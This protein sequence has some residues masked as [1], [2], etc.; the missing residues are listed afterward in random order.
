MLQIFGLSLPVLTKVAVDHILPQQLTDAVRLLGIAMLLFI[1][2][3]IAISYLRARLL[4]FLE[5]RLDTRM[6]LGFFQ[7]LLALP[8]GFF[9]RHHRGDLLMRLGNNT[10]IRD[11]M[12]NHT[13]SAVLDGSLI[14][15]YLGVLLV[16]DPM[17]GTI[18]L[19][20]AVAQVAIFLATAGH[21][22]RLTEKEI[23]AHVE[24]QSYA[25]EA[26]SAIAAVKAAGA[27]DQILARWRN[28]FYRYKN[29]ALERSH[30]TSLLDTATAG[31]RLLAPFLLM[32]VGIIRVLDGS[33]SLGSMLAMNMLAAAFL[34]PLSSLIAT[35]QRL[36][37]VKVHLDRI[38]DVVDT[39]TE[40]GEGSRGSKTRLSGHIELRNVSF[41]YGPHSPIVLKDVSLVVKPGEKLALVG[42]T[43]CGKSTLALLMLGLYQPSHGEILC[44]GVPLSKLDYRA[45]RA[46]FGVVMQDA[47]IFSGSIRQNISFQDPSMDLE[48]IVRSAQLARIHEDIMSMPMAYE[49]RLAEGGTG[50]SGGQKQRLSLARALARDPAVL[51]LDEATSHLDTATEAEVQRNL[52]VLSCT[53]ILIAH[54]ISTIRNAEKIVLLDQG[55][56]LDSGTHDELAGRCEL[57]ARMVHGQSA[58][59]GVDSITSGPQELRA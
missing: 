4:L 20:I 10:A 38:V 35:A 5:S 36:Q 21:L 13:M 19:G 58:D 33:L 24:S 39:A 48:Q 40:Q 8:F 11:I 29:A 27:E 7:H 57:Y 50:L 34:V 54:R 22:R 15:V 6:M 45:L 53:Q 1:G 2:V 18:A 9:Q 59:F 43:G 12:T 16:A 56:I 55:M 26:L 47:G 46:Q 44:D 23:H 52:D 41:S 30:C 28:L 49:T 25:T 31:L 51:L 17:L 42:R 3:Q 32:W 37:L 14:V